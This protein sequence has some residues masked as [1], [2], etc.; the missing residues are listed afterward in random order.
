MQYGNAVDLSRQG[1]QK[2]SQIEDANKYMHNEFLKINGCFPTAVDSSKLQVSFEHEKNK[3]NDVEKYMS[4]FRPVN[5]DGPFTLGDY[6][7][8]RLSSGCEE[9]DQEAMSPNA[10]SEQSDGS[11]YDLMEEQVCAEPE[12]TDINVTDIEQNDSVP[13]PHDINKNN[14]SKAE[15]PNSQS[16]SPVAEGDMEPKTNNANVST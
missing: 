2:I 4:A 8:L 15:C 14:M 12:E 10:Q 16:V 11:G 5:K 3:R 9:I 1:A 7:Q 6:K 13:S